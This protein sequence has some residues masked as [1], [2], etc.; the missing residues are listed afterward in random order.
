MWF[1]KH[2]RIQRERVKREG[3]KLEERYDNIETE[4]Q[5]YYNNQIDPKYVYN[6]LLDFEDRSRRCNPRIDG[7]TQRKGEIWEQRDD[8]I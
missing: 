1:E 8:E 7:V 3:K 4:L 6:E 2:S 5:E